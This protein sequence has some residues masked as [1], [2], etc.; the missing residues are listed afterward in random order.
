MVRRA[1]IAMTLSAVAVLAVGLSMNHRSE[2][3]PAAITCKEVGPHLAEYAQGKCD[4]ELHD[5][6]E[7]HLAHCH[8]CV[9]HLEEV[10]QAN[11]AAPS[12][13]L[14]LLAAMW[15]DAAESSR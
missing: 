14:A 1:A 8:R 5:R 2:A 13:R 6:I 15:S 4:A 10:R 12:G 11:A 3:A 7:H 9:E